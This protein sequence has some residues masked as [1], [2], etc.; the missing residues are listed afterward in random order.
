MR[1][2]GI[3]PGLQVTGYG[4]LESDGDK[5]QVL[6][7]GVIRS[8]SAGALETRLK[9]IASELDDILRQ[10]APDAMA[11][12]ELYSHYDHPITAIV[13]GHVRGVIMVR[14]AES[15]IPIISYAPTRIK[16]ALTGNGR[17]TKGQMQRMV[18]SSRSSLSTATVIVKHSRS[19]IGLSRA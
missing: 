4:L 17:A 1:I 11:I 13:M 18:Q 7:A 9:E 14:A 19:A 6:E 16:K 15:R 2:L 10:F 3:D 12:E 8:D 5:L